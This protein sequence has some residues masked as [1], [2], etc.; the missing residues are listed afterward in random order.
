[1]VLLRTLGQGDSYLIVPSSTCPAMLLAH[2]SKVSDVPCKDGEMF[3]VLG[4]EDITDLLLNQFPQANHGRK[5][6]GL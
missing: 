3:S 5:L 1:M 2:V 6:R 4:A